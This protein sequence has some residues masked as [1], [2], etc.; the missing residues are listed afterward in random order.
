MASGTQTVS[1]LRIYPN[2]ED[3]NSD[4]VLRCLLDLSKKEEKADLVPAAKELMRMAAARGDKGL[5][6]SDWKKVKEELEITESQYFYIL[7]ILKNAGILYKSKGRFYL[8]KVFGTH[9]S[10]MASAWNARM[11]D[12]GA[13]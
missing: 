3:F 4:Y 5:F 12:L 6:A 7:K 11:I 13:L 10:K 2:L 9:L 8:S 1:R